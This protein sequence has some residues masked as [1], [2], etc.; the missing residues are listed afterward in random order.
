MD[1]FSAIHIARSGLSVQRTRVN[2]ASSNLANLETTETPEGGP[3]RRRS[4]IVRASPVRRAFPELYEGE[5]GEKVHSAE[6]DRIVEDEGPPQKRFMPGHPQADEEGY[7][8]VPN[9]NAIQEMVDLLTASRSYEA[10]V[11]ALK[12]I[13]GMAQE[14]LSIGEA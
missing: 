2:I 6:V 11:S 8:E 12:S 13:K 1:F 5:M 14:A 3:Y 4:V 7:V 9:I 10:G